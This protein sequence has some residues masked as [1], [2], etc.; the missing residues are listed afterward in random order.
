MSLSTDKGWRKEAPPL[1]GRGL[2]WGLSVEQLAELHLRAKGMRRNPT[3]PEKR[4]WRNLSNSQLD[5][6][7]F[8][9]QSVIG[10]S[11]ADFFCPDRKLIVEIDGDTHDDPVKDASRDAAFERR[12]YRVL[13]VSNDDVMTNIDG[14][15]A[16]ISQALRS[17]DMPH[18]NPSPK[19]EGLEKEKMPLEGSRPGDGPG[20]IVQRNKICDSTKR[21]ET[22]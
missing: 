9:R 6:C 12:G 10:F 13:H 17:V 11:I 19:E 22:C 1:K 14:V 4:L 21:K 8:R 3:E 7:K 5:G 15:L 18:P 20:L 2:G 16:F